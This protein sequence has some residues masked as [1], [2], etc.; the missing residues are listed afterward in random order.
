LPRGVI[1][2]IDGTLVDSNDAHAQ[3]WLDALKEFGFSDISFERVRRMIGMGGDKILPDLVGLGE[4]DERG[5]KLLDR[6]KQIFLQH[7]LPGLKA[8]PGS[9]ELVERIKQEG[10]LAV[11]ASSANSKELTP[12][13]KA[14][15]VDDLMDETTSSSDAEDSKPDP[16]IV[17]AAVAKTHL[18]AEQLIMLGDTPYDIEAAKGAGVPVVA[19][20]CGGWSDRD[21][22]GALAVYDDPADILH[23]YERTHFAKPH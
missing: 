23:N 11:V 9:R 17:R 2:D 8:F 15:R 12:L 5:K 7:Y 21:L 19:V 1:F 4:D 6:R 20:R 14:A 3:A 18:P 13:L 16:D 10:M 22:E